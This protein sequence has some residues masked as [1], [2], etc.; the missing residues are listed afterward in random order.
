MGRDERQREGKQAVAEQQ[1]LEGA[2]EAAAAGPMGPY[3]TVLV[4]LLKEPRDLGIARDE[5]WYRIPVRS[6]PARAVG[7]AILAFYQTKAFGDERWAI[8]YYA[9]AR[10]WTQVRRID[11]LPQEAGHPRAQDPYYQVWLGPLKPLP[12]P[13]ASGR[14]RRITFI[15]THWERLQSVEAVED[16]LHGSLWDEYLWRA[17]RNL[18]YLAEDI[19]REL[20][21]W[22]RISPGPHL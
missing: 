3:T 19:I 12:R 21:G 10:R 1:H 8:R 4:A 13:I 15:V 14:W 2:K 6:L 22:F 20:R 11:L 9:E 16:L 7:A 18:G 17:M 5:H